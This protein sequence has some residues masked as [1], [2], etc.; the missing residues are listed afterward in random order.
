MPSHKQELKDSHLSEAT[1]S[2]VLSLP[3]D[4]QAL[5][6]F[7]REGKAH[8]DEMEVQAIE[9][10]ETPH[11]P[12]ALNELTKR[13]NLFSSRAYLLRLG[14]IT[15]LAEELSVVFSSLEKNVLSVNK[16]IMDLIF[17]SID[18]LRGECESIEKALEG[19]SE[20]HLNP[21]IKSFIEKLRREISSASIQQLGRKK[22]HLRAAARVPGESHQIVRLEFERFKKLKES[23]SRLHSMYTSVEDFKELEEEWEEFGESLCEVHKLSEQLDYV[24][25]RSFFPFLQRLSRDYAQRLQR[26]TSIILEAEEVA[27]SYSVI[28]QLTEPLIH[29]IQNAFAHGIESTSERLEKGK[30]IQSLLE[31]RIFTDDEFLAIQVKDDGRGF[32]ASEIQVCAEKMGVMESGEELDLESIL[33]TPGFSTRKTIDEWGGSGIGLDLVKERITS[34]GGSIKWLSVE[35]KGCTWLLLLPK[36]LVASERS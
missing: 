35:G 16:S 6:E 7:L 30:S 3:S 11:S 17:P 36:S 20:Y 13:L 9:L 21:Q 32:C 5:S 18:L 10:E 26:N 1:N 31:I 14:Q 19:I 8:L 34:L 4:T 12:S 22:S 33:L 15:A 29:L 27:V 2:E 28:E 24:S 23:I 25:V